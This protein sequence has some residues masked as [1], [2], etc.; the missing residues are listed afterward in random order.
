VSQKSDAQIHKYIHLFYFRRNVHIIQIVITIYYTCS[1]L[2]TIWLAYML[3]ISTKFCRLWLERNKGWLIDWLIDWQYA[4]RGAAWLVERATGSWACRPISGRAVIR[5]VWPDV[6]VRWTLS[7]SPASMSPTTVAACAGVPRARTRYENT[8]LTPRG[9]C[10]S[11]C[12]LQRFDT[13]DW[14]TGRASDL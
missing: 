4:R 12:L 14:V 6:T 13:V 7:A 11:E 8:M 10:R 1:H 9:S 5:S 3:Q 2:I